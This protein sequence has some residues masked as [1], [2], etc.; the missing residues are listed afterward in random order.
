MRVDS[1]D[2]LRDFKKRIHEKG[3]RRRLTHLHKGLEDG[4]DLP[5]FSMKIEIP[6]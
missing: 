1:L 2:D 3:Y 5:V 6:Q 4:L